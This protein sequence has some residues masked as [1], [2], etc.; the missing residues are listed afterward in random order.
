MIIVIGSRHSSG[1]IRVMSATGVARS[2][3][4]CFSF[5]TEWVDSWTPGP[6]P[7]WHRHPTG[8]HPSGLLWTPA[9]GDSMKSNV[10]PGRRSELGR[11]PQ[12]R[13]SELAEDLGDNLVG[14]AADIDHDRPLVGT[15]LLERRELAVEQ[16]DRHEM[17]VPRRHPLVDQLPGPPEIDQAH[18]G[19]GAD[20]DVSVAALQRR[21]GDDA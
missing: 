21:A 1:A 19:P 4:G 11:A 5:G 12:Q 17:L 15:R 10:A 16:A 8:P 3:E 13:R 2:D 6:K 14:R 9:G 7:L 18:L 20:Q